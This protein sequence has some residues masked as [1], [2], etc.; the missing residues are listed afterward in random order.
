M[1]GPH[2]TAPVSKV[3]YGLGVVHGGSGPSARIGHSGEDPGFS[4]RAWV[5]T[6]SGERVVVQSNVSEGAAH[7]Y[8]RLE[9]LLAAG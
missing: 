5:Y 1:I 9:A 7:A 2:A 4:S 3:G 8:E 6:A